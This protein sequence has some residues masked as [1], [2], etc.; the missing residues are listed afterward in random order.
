MNRFDVITE[1]LETTLLLPGCMAEVGVYK[2]VTAK[3]V[4]NLAPLKDM[5]L[6]DTFQGIVKADSSI[7]VHG[8]GDF[9]DTSFETVKKDLGEDH[10]YY[11]VGTFPDTFAEGHLSFC[12]VY[13]DTDTYFG[14][15]ATLEIFSP[16]M[17]SGGILMFHDYDWKGCPG[18]KKAISEFLIGKNLKCIYPQSPHTQCSIIF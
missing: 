15:K 5:H 12:F 1:V 14:T 2:G 9:S 17:V 8:N 7:D 11:H 18:V 13:S 16:I 4:H 6:Y 3:F 10:I